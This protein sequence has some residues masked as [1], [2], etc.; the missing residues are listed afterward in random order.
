MKLDDGPPAGG[1]AECARGPRPCLRF[2][3]DKHMFWLAR[4]PIRKLPLH[5]W[6]MTCQLDTPPWRKAEATLQDIAKV[7]GLTRERVR[8]I[9][10]A[11]L[12]K[13]VETIR[14]EE[15]RSERILPAKA[16]AAKKQ[17]KA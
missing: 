13:L 15:K 8:Q 1:R 10:E 5:E 12:V 2:R 17:A 3:C 11:T 9:F 14:K 16:R 6:P 4:E 7:V